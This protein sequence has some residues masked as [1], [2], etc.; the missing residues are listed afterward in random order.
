MFPSLHCCLILS[1]QIQQI[2]P[3]IL[4]LAWGSGNM[5]KVKLLLLPPKAIFLNLC[6]PGGAS[7]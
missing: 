5:I 6:G 2:P 7:P 4:V 3:V 1:G